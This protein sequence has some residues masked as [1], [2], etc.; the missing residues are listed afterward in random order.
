M[1]TAGVLAIGVGVVVLYFAGAGVVK[2]GKW[3]GHQTKVGVCRVLH[4]CTKK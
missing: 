2:G 4:K 1:P 3:V